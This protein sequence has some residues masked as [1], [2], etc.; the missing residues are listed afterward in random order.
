MLCLFRAANHPAG[1]P[2]VFLNDRPRFW[3]NT[4]R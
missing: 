1:V 3:G 4:R 2:N